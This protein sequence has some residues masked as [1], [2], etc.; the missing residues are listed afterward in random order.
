[1]K[2]P[3]EHELSQQLFELLK[4][5]PSLDLSKVNI[6]QIDHLL[7]LDGEVENQEM[8]NLIN[9][10]I[11]TNL[12]EVDLINSLTIKKNKGLVGDVNDSLKMI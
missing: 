11:R 5:V 12:N 4:S 7:Y 1:M 3:N 8:K 2:S 10:T 9:Q 6:T